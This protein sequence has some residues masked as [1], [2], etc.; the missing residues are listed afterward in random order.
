MKKLVFF[1]KRSLDSFLG[2]IISELSKKY[3]VKKIIV[4]F[5][6]EIDD[7]MKWADICWFEWCDDLVIYGSRL[8][9]AKEKIVVCRLHSYEVFT[10]YINQV[11]WA[12][13]D[14][15]ICVGKNI[16]DI[17]KMKVNI[18]DNKI[19]IIQNGIDENK[20]NYKD[21]CDGFNIAYV[22]YINFKKGPMLLV[23]T[24]R[25][26]CEKDKRYKLYIAGVFQDERYVLYFS[27]MIKEMNLE[28]SIIYDGWQNDL[29]KWLEDKNYILCT[30]VLESQ[31]LSVMQ[32]MSKG[33]KPI[34]H[35]F[36]GAK[37]IYPRDYLWN[38]IDEA[39]SMVC[40]HKYNSKEYRD[41]IINNYSLTMQQ[42]K[43]SKLMDDLINDN[44]I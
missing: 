24:F 42:N 39:V 2:D 37:E 29:N 18:E 1:V 23:H 10:E 3:I 11:N 36:V 9:I 25:A 32:A 40:N 21:R 28:K 27:Q 7:A 33:I 6:S 38:D 13:V 12:N 16:R 5:Y 17:L 8:D 30:S 43:I 31:N 35:N 4:N 34:I 22:G 15:L 19:I 41:F 26:I 20:Y 14:K 44:G